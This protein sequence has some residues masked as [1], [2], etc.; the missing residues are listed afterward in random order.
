MLGHGG[1]L[2]H[3][4]LTLFLL[5]LQHV[6][7]RLTDDGRLVRKG[8]RQVGGQVMHHAEEEQIN[9]NQIDKIRSEQSRYYSKMKC[10]GLL[11]LELKKQ[12]FPSQKQ[13]KIYDAQHF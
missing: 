9:S 3:K 12:P 6:T 10:I 2:V 1:D 4:L 5:Q 7:R 8:R 13:M 11:E